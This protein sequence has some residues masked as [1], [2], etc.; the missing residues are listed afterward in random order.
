MK[1][2]LAENVI[3]TCL[4][5]ILAHKGGGVAILSNN[6]TEFKYKAVNDTCDQLGIRGLLPTCSI[7]KVIQE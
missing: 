3:Q 2:R 4:S 1:E 5:G 6:G 7:P